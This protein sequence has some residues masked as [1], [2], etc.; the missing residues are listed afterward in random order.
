M[1]EADLRNELGS[2]YGFCAAVLS[3]QKTSHVTL[4]NPKIVCHEQSTANGAYAI[5]GGA[6]VIEGGTI[7]TCNRQGHGVDASYGG[8]IYCNGTVIHTGGSKSGA[9]ATD[10]Q[11]G[12]ITVR[13]IDATTEIPGSPGHLYRRQV[14]YHRIQLQVP[15]EGLRGG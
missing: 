8:H 14:H 1:N 13:D 12:Y 5:F 10:F 4:V 7:D 11:G 15:V 6:V 3:N 2:K 9:L